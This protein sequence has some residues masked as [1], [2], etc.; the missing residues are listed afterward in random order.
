M[1]TVGT[2]ATFGVLVESLASTTAVAGQSFISN[3]GIAAVIAVVRVRL[4][5][6][7]YFR[8]N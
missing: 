2:L 3:E 7:H 4:L 6:K 8:N 1:V 5:N